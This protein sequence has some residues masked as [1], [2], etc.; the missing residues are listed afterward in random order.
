MNTIFYEGFIKQVEYYS[1]TIDS[2]GISAIKRRQSK[3][4]H[5]KSSIFQLVGWHIK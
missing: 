2:E 3:K 4:K 5:F 1:Q